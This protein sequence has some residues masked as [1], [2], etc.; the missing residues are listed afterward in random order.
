MRCSDKQKFQFWILFF[1][2]TVKLNNFCYLKFLYI[3]ETVFIV[4]QLNII[5]QYCD[6]LDNL[7]NS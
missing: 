6:H 2:K 3:P 5:E 7:L 1:L 4:T